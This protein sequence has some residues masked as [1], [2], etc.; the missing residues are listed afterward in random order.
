MKPITRKDLMTHQEY[1]KVAKRFLNEVI[2]EKK[3]RRVRINDKMSGLFETRLTV[4]Y[5][6]MEMIRAERI[7]DEDYIQEMLDVYNDLIPADNELSMTFFVEIPNQQELRQF[8]K[9][10]VG[11]EDHIQLVFGEH[12]VTSY[13]PEDGEEEDE[14]YTQSVHYLRIP[15]SEEEKNA[16]VAHKGDVIVKVTHPNFQSE[17]VLPKEAVESLQKELSDN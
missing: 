1:A 6:I 17:E 14:N 7:E 10:I 16:F 13:E 12:T 3:I 9:T 4:W 11:I 2:N 5:Q 8:N 15:F